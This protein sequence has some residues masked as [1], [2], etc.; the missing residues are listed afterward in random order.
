MPNRLQRRLISVALK[1]DAR[2]GPHPFR[3]LASEKSLFLG[4]RS[5]SP[6]AGADGTNPIC[7]LSQGQINKSDTQRSNAV[8]ERILT[9]CAI[10]SR[11]AL[12]TLKL[13]IP[14][15]CQGPTPARRAALASESVIRSRREA[16]G[17]IAAASMR[18]HQTRLISQKEADKA[19]TFSLDLAHSFSRQCV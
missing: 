18:A 14:Q 1:R 2:F 19:I 11:K 10:I 15:R 13:C 8:R 7:T 5:L 3:S 16:E 6:V 9:P 17:L 4:R 12:E